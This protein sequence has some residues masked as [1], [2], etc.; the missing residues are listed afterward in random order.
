MEIRNEA[1]KN[2]K[3][4]LTGFAAGM[5]FIWFFYVTNQ[6]NQPYVISYTEF[7]ENVEEGV[8]HKWFQRPTN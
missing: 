1:R 8:Y 3:H 2:M 6:D 4:H 7:R 5:I